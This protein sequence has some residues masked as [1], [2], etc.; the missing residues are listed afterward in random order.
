MPTDKPT[1][2]GY[3]A[4]AIALIKLFEPLI[5]YLCI[6]TIGDFLSVISCSWYHYLVLFKTWKTW[7]CTFL[8]DHVWLWI[9]CVVLTAWHTLAK[10]HGHPH[11]SVTGISDWPTQIIGHELIVCT[12]I[13]I[14]S[15]LTGILFGCCWRMFCTSAAR[16]S[17]TKTVCCECCN[18]EYK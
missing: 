10:C 4:F 3:L 12:N 16:S 14:T 6:K 2:P 8:L 18:R 13:R 9:A 7:I 11:R 1:H 17:V 5:K 15:K